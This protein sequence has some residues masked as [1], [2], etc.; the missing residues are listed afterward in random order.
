MTGMKKLLLLRHAK[1][2]WDEP[3]QRDFDRILNPRGRAAARAM[4]SEFTAR[5]IVPDCI[6]CSPAKRTRETLSLV[7]ES[8]RLAASLQLKDDI[9]MASAETLLGLI[10]GADSAASTLLMIGHNPGF[11]DL[12]AMLVATGD[13]RL[14]TAMDDKFPTATLAQINFDVSDWQDVKKSSGQLMLFIR[15][16]DFGFSLEDEG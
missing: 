2:S 8:A 6:F 5:K 4:G 7:Q 10:Q 9:Y 13:A 1:S 16:R 3:G 15:P 11:E 14:R 12:A